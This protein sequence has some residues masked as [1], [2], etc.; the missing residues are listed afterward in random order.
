MFDKRVSSAEH[1]ETGRKIAEK[2]AERGT[3]QVSIYAHAFGSVA[4]HHD[5]MLAQ[6][7]A[8]EGPIAR[9]LQAQYDSRGYLTTIELDLA[10][11]AGWTPGCYR[12]KA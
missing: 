11:V 6:L 5:S 10:R 2:M 3:G 7:E 9:V 12:E 8:L 4:V 1:L